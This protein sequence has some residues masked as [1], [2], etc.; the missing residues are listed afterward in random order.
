MDI[1]AKFPSDQQKFFKIKDNAVFEKDQSKIHYTCTNCG[2]D[3]HFE[4]NCYELIYT[5]KNYF[6]EY[7]VQ[8]YMMAIRLFGKCFKRP[9]RRKHKTLKENKD[10]KLPAFRIQNHFPN[11]I[12]SL[13]ENSNFPD[14]DENIEKRID[15]ESYKKTYTFPERILKYE[16]P[17]DVL[18]DTYME[19]EQR[20]DMHN[21]QLNKEM[22]NL[23]HLL[24]RREIKAKVQA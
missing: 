20:L 5:E 4:F 23:K 2:E 7:F 24:L 21:F 12:M 15:T 8:Y 19:L 16:N 3:S 18:A 9:Q 6:S 14:F 22:I 10:I 13:I 17:E 11:E 1:L